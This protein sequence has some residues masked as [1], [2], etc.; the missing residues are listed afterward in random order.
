VGAR[1][2]IGREPQVA[3]AKG[4]D[5]RTTHLHTIHAGDDGNG[6]GVTVGRAGGSFELDQIDAGTVHAEWKINRA[7][8]GEGTQSAVREHRPST[9]RSLEGG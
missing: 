3:G 7:T 1:G 4:D 5:L 6:R 2:E 8:T 9:R